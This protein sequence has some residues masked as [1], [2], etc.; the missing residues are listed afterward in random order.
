MQ[1]SESIDFIGF[2]F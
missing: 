2:S 1:T